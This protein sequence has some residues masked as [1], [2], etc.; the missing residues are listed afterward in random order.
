MMKKG[1]IFGV[2]LLLSISLQAKM[3]ICDSSSC[4]SMK[5]QDVS[6]VLDAVKKTFSGGQKEMVFCEADQYSKSCTNQ[7]ITFSGRTNLMGVHFQ[8]PFVRI[9]YVKSEKDTLQ[10]LLDYQVRANQYYPVCKPV[11]SVLNYSKENFGNFILSS[12]DFECQVTELG[13]SKMNVHFIFDYMDVDKGVLG[14][15]YQFTINGDVH[16]KKTGYALLQITKMREIIASRITPTNLIF[17]AEYLTNINQTDEVSVN[18]EALEISDIHQ[19]DE[20][21]LNQNIAFSV[22]VNPGEENSE[23]EAIQIANMEPEKEVFIESN[24]PELH[25]GNSEREAKLVDWNNIK[26]KWDSF[27]TKFMKILYLEPLDD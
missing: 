5:S 4:Q 27:S 8:I 7:P 13:T 9:L 25:Q 22:D 15:V 6:Q 18:K 20:D 23:Q 16:A 21:Q 1:I 24:Q 11:N 26:K 12:F 14:G 2:V 17:D 3:L 10:M 19:V